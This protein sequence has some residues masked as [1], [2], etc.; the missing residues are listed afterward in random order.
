MVVSC[1]NFAKFAPFPV[2]TLERRR[3][4]IVMSYPIPV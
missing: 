1:A 4:R 3:A 2:K